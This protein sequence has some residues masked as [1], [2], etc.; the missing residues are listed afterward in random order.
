MSYFQDVIYFRIN[1]KQVFAQKKKKICLNFDKRT[2]IIL[3]N[4]DNINIEP[5]L[6]GIAQYISII[7]EYNVVV[8]HISYL[9]YFF[10]KFFFFTNLI[11][12]LSTFI[13]YDKSSHI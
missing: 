1:W 2:K 10:L 4:Y 13:V 6:G 9:S 11:N 5:F 12:I 3:H 7:N 8:Y